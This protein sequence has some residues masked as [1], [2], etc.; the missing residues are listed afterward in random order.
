MRTTFDAF[1]EALSR[2]DLEVVDRDVDQ[3]PCVTVARDG[4]SV[5][6]ELARRSEGS[7]CY[8]RTARFDVSARPLVRGDALDERE[9]ALADRAIAVLRAWEASLVLPERATVE[10]GSEIREIEVDRA[11]VAEGEGRYYLNP[12]V[13]CTIGCPFCWVADRADLG[14]ALSGR[15]AL[16]WGRWVDVKVNLPAIVREEVARLAPGTVRMSPVVTDPY[17]PLERRY[18]VSRGCIQALCEARFI[19]IVLTRARLVLEDLPLFAQH[20][21]SLAVGVSIPTDDDDVR[22]AFERSADPI[23]ARL[24]TLR[25]LKAAGVVTFA[26]IQPVLP[27]N[28]ERLVA[29]IA[30]HVDAVRI[31]RMHE[32]ERALPIYERAGRLEAADPRFADSTTASLAAGFAAAGVPIDERDDLASMVFDILSPRRLS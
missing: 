13:G 1:A 17:Q 20:L 25:A 6:L 9:R 11:L 2:A 16:P 29:S 14:R 4:A 26:V 8:A 23:D 15:A 19:P 5:F 32:V 27:M 7:P 3:G 18:R 10:R 22:R 31:D 30:P 21:D 28:A 24:E 12:Y